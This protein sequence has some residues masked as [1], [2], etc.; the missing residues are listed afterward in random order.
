MRRIISQAS[1]RSISGSQFLK[2]AKPS[3]SLFP[4]VEKDCFGEPPKPTREPRVLPRHPCYPREPWAKEKRRS[5]AALQ[6]IRVIRAIGGRLVFPE[7][8]VH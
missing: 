5:S 4:S 8:R 3:L 1:A 7:I 6:N 2:L